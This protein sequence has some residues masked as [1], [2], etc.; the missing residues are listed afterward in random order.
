[1]KGCYLALAAS[2]AQETG[3]AAASFKAG[4]LTD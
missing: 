4:W 3:A 2:C 1:M